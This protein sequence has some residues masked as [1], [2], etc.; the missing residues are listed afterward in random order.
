MAIYS[1]NFTSKL[2][3]LFLLLFDDR[4]AISITF[5]N[6]SHAMTANKP[7]K[8]CILFDLF[9]RLCRCC[10]CAELAS[11]VFNT[12]Q[13]SAQYAKIWW[14][15]CDEID[16]TSAGIHT[17]AHIAKI[18]RTKHSYSTLYTLLS[19]RSINLTASCFFSLTA[20]L[21]YSST[22]WRKKLKKPLKEKQSLNFS[23]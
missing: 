19:Y 14:K 5:G 3:I 10:G 16:V 17:E 1:R 2:T 13:N 18:K 23:F 20:T 11:S 12:M 4:I 9:A 22:L 15:T 8:K 7:A 21:N 6:I